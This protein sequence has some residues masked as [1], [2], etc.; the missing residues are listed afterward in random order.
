MNMASKLSV[1]KIVESAHMAELK[2]TKDVPLKTKDGLW[3]NED[4]L[5]KLKIVQV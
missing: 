5:L 4:I 2:K 1:L 3:K